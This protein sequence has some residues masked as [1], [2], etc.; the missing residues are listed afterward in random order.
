MMKQTIPL[1]ILVFV[2]I[3]LIPTFCISFDINN[4]KYKRGTDFWTVDI[5]L[6]NYTSSYLIAFESLP[7]GWTMSGNSLLIPT[8]VTKYDGN[9]PLK[10]SVQGAAGILLRR[11]LLFKV[12][13]SGL[14]L[15]DYPYDYTFQTAGSTLQS[16]STLQGNFTGA[17]IQ[18]G[19][20]VTSLAIN[21]SISGSLRTQYS[22][23]PSD[24]DLDKIIDSADIVLITKTIQAV[25]SSNLNCLAKMGYLSDFLGKINSYI[26]IK[27]FRASDLLDIIKTANQTIITLQANINLYLG[28]I[29]G[30]KITSLKLQLNQALA[31]LDAAYA[32]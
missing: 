16:P 7:T 28:Q 14:Y 12:S 24:S 30:L 32:L 1:V 26:T 25:I 8:A 6:L 18:N 21:S 3:L 19:E 13:G 15:G 20:G 9:Y 31:N 11:T 4:A 23:L 29:D 27:G 17:Y 2:S 10:V 5:P 22:N